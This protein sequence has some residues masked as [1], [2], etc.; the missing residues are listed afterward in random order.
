MDLLDKMDPFT[1]GSNESIKYIS[2]NNESFWSHYGPVGSNIMGPSA[3]TIDFDFESIWFQLF[4]R[5][6]PNES[7][8]LIVIGT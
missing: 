2:F 8:R 7:A 1:I 3:G 6:G 5:A 4:H